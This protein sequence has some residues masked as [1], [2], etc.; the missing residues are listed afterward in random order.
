MVGSV[1]TSTPFA[2]GHPTLSPST[3]IAYVAVFE[4]ANAEGF[5]LADLRAFWRHSRIPADVAQ[6]R[7]SY[8][9]ASMGSEPGFGARVGFFG[10]VNAGDLYG[11]AYA[12]KPEFVHASKF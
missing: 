4:G 5:A 12:H 8:T 6:Q 2:S 7:L 11:Y 10:L 3:Q 9:S 1:T